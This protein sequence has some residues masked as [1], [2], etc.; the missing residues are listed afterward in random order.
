MQRIQSTNGEGESVELSVDALLSVIS[1]A[2]AGVALFDEALRLVFA[3]QRYRE[4]C[5]YSRVEAAR[6]VNLRDLAAINMRRAGVA[7]ELIAERVERGL[8]RLHS[9]GGYSFRMESPLGVRVYAHRRVLQDG[10]VSEF[11]QEV[12]AEAHDP[13]ADRLEMIAEAA[14][15][16]MLHAL[17]AMPDGFALFDA[18][19]RLMVYNRQFVE[20]NPAIEDEIAPGA[21]YE[22]MLRR[23]VERGAYIIGD[24][25][26][27]DYV[28]WRLD[29]HHNPSEA[30]D[31]QMQD[32]RWVRVRER[33]TLE[34][35]IVKTRSDVTEL[36]RR[37]AEILSV[38]KAL[39]QKN[40]HFNEALNNMIQGLCMFDADQNLIVCNQRYLQMYGF[41]PDVVKP[42]IKLHEIMEYSVSIGNYTAE[43]AEKAK[44]ARPDHARSRTRSTLKQYLRD[45]RV[46]AVMHEP[47]PSGGSIATYQDVTEA[48]RREISLQQYTKRLEASNRELQDFAYVASHDLQEPLRKIETFGERLLK[49]H[50]A[51][52]PE[53]GQ[54]FLG[55]M[56][57]ATGRMRQLINDLLDYSRVTTKARPF[58]ETPLAGV[59]EGVL[60][61][62]QIRISETGAEIEAGPLPAIEVDAMQMRQLFQNIIGNA[63]KFQEEG[64]RPHVRITARTIP[65]SFVEGKPDMCEIRIADNGIGFDEKYKLQIFTIFQRLHGRNE[66]E[67]TGIGLATCRKIV[68]RHNGDIDAESAPGQG[69]TFV[70]TLPRT[71]PKSREEEARAED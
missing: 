44:A 6:G 71:H 51:H 69:A 3:D 66:Y 32:G 18:D 53:E 54:L 23:S 62:L 22:G 43:D 16:R 65:G 14:R 57:N 63:L 1:G 48:E 70:I 15:S 36:K 17:E 5:G 10:R 68:E 40:L 64:V 49:K 46:I 33:R 12:A 50:G 20:L 26:E 11:V 60:S 27:E 24:M 58:V 2:N 19:D 38:S 7:E 52:L 34:G 4:L 39:H 9:V 21:T 31:L 25:T 41:S 67:G 42:G 28:A 8:A 37:E 47:M 29:R 61:D 30:F 35:G 13:G 59:L 56:Q 55:R 45:G